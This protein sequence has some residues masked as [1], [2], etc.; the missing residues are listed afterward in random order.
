MAYV[1]AGG[2]KYMLPQAPRGLSAEEKRVKLLE[3]FHETKDFFQL[4]E[5]EKL[6]P[7]LK[8]IVSQSVKEVIQS[9]V[10]DNLVCSDKIGTSNFFWSFPSARGV[11]LNT[12]VDN[13]KS[14]IT[15]LKSSVADLERS[16]A[17]ENA[18]RVM[19]S[20]RQAALDQHAQ[21]QARLTALNREREQYGASDPIQINAK[22]R[23]VELAR[24]AAVRYTDNTLAVISHLRNTHG[25]DAKDVRDHLEIPDDWDDI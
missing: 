14:T 12:K 1:R 20:E 4:K 25:V 7:K 5:L 3:I 18:E 24:E 13:L 8:G 17:E 16:I 11:M 21:L 6:G 10:D 15:S 19:T 2:L 9:L 23:A 22:R